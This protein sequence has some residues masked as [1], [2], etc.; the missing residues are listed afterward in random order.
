MVEKYC[1]ELLIKPSEIGIYI[2]IYIYIY[3]G[4]ECGNNVDWF[5]EVPVV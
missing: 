1:N 2:Y 5:V 3:M 4:S